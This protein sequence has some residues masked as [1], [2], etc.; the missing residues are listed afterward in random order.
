M[1]LLQGDREGVLPVHRRAELSPEE[2]E[3][4]VVPLVRNGICHLKL[5]G[6]EPGVRQLAKG[7]IVEIV[8]R[9]RRI[10]GVASID[11]V[12]RHPVIGDL[13]CELRDAGAT[14]LNFSLDSM[15]PAVWEWIT[16]VKGHEQ[17]V[18]SIRN[19]ATLG[20]AVRINTVIMKGVNDGEIEKLIEFAAETGA[21]LKLL[22]LIRDVDSHDGDGFGERHYRDISQLFGQLASRVSERRTVS[23]PGGLGHPMDQV[24]LANGVTLTFKSLRQG[25]YYSPQLCKRCRHFP[26]DDAIMA[27]RLTP[28]GMLQTCLI[29]DDNLVDLASLVRCARPTAEIDGLMQR[30]LNIYRTAVFMPWEVI[31]PERLARNGYTRTCA[32]D[33]PAWTLSQSQ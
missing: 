15:D 31:E 19:A 7:D 27:L 29:R 18:T 21:E 20:L 9:L 32:Y 12:T 16:R 11:I 1:P 28:D 26:C 3:M 2:M 6:G 24:V 14:L 25:A 30:V 17:L 23:Q 13:A 4:V 22:E 10:P 5:T 33:V 8:R